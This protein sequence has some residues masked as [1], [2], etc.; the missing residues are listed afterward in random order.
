MKKVIFPIITL[1]ALACST[2]SETLTTELNEEGENNA[3]I[4]NA[5]AFS[6]DEH[7]LAGTVIGTISALDS[8]DNELTYSIDDESGLEINENTGEVTI[9]SN[10]IL[11]FETEA[12]LPFTVSVFD[13]TILVDKNFE[14]EIN[15]I[16]EYDLL[17]ESQKETIA[18]FNYLT[19]WQSPTHTA[20]LNNSRWVAPM[21]IYLDGSNPEFKTIVEGVIEEYN[22]LFENSD[23]N[24]SIV[25]TKEASNA[26]LFL[27]E[28]ADVEALWEDMFAIIN[29]KT[30]NGYAM[31]SNSNSILSTSRI[32]LSVSSSILF[33]HELGHALGFGHSEKCETENSFMCSNISN[34]HD[35]L[36]TEK[37]IIRLAYDN[38]LPAGLT[39][40]EIILFLANKLILEN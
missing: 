40:E 3:P 24:I 34:D 7:S 6:A 29:G 22:V 8:D 18:Y 5:Q 15:D 39:E 30:Y 28:T 27:G 11:D 12:T 37:E 26:H 2:D 36:E 35:F 31:T 14:L 32:W 4:I 20:L 21:K 33:K 1:L 13:G 19:L 23:F 16:N 9:G 38:D 25:E 17:S 10:L